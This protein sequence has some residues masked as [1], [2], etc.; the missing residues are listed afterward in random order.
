[1]VKHILRGTFLGLLGIVAAASAAAGNVSVQPAV[2]SP[3]ITSVSK[4]TTAQHQTITIKGTGFGTF[5]AYTGNSRFIW[6]R[7]LPPSGNANQVQWEAGYSPDGDTVT[8]IVK[9]WSNTQIVLGGFAG[10]WGTQNFTL[11]KGDVEQIRVWNWQ[12][13]PPSS[14]SAIVKVKIE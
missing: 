11:K 6:L 8:L 10:K 7:E 1:M 13:N 9:S 12:G 3:K 14:P 5:H 2:A 4:I